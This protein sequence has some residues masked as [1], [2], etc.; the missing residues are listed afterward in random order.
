MSQTALGCPQTF[1]QDRAGPLIRPLSGPN[2]SYSIHLH[3]SLWA[4]V[5]HPG[6]SHCG[7]C[8]LVLPTPPKTQRWQVGLSNLALL[9]MGCC[10]GPRPPL[11]P[12]EML[13]QPPPQVA[14]PWV[15]CGTAASAVQ[16]GPSLGPP[17]PHAHLGGLWECCRE[18]GPGAL[19]Q[20]GEGRHPRVLSDEVPP[21][22]AAR[23]VCLSSA[24]P[25]RSLLIPGEDLGSL[26]NH[27]PLQCARNPQSTGFTHSAH[28]CP[29][30]L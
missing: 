25:S 27:T 2:Q 28:M 12:A 17:A 3:S 10:P 9:L 15:C 1:L 26:V 16:C 22:P 7:V 24:G 20:E 5:T 19:I 14:R 11:F 6:I 18:R 4:Q 29:G 23:T 30:S 21:A 8:R 13:R